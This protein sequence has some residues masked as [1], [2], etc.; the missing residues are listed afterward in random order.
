MR[1]Y[2]EALPFWNNLD[3]AEKKLAEDSAVIKHFAA[4]NFLGG[5]S[6]D[7][8][9]CLGMV[10]VISGEL[11][12][13]ILSEE[14]REITLFRLAEGDNCVLSASCVISQIDFDTELS[15]TKDADI[16]LIPSSVFGRLTKENVY[17]RCF[18]YETATKRFSTVMWVMQQILFYRF[19]RRLAFYLLSEYE[20]SGKPQIRMTQE[21]IA[22]NINSAREVVA[23]MLK[24][25]SSD[26]IIENGRGVITIKDVKALAR[27]IE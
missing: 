3:E 17:V 10:H 27:I 24:Q 26:G 11:R 21:E 22:R 19:D 16:L 2:L 18:L 6:A 1:K 14:G 7:G 5:N 20:K 9:S 23:R 13:Y 25:F 8:G 15:V 12:A 4:G